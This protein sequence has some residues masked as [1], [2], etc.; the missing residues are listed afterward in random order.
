MEDLSELACGLSLLD[1]VLSLDL[2]RDEIDLGER[3]HL[4]MLEQ[5]FKQDRD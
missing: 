2:T 1:N 5:H 3:N 4:R